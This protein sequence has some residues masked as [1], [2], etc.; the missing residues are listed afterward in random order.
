MKKEELEKFL[1][2]KGIFPSI[3]RIKI[4]EFLQKTKNHP[5]AD[6]IHKIVS[7]Q[8]PTLSRTTVYNTLKL[9][10][11]MK[12]VKSLSIKGNE[13]RYDFQLIPHAHFRCH[14]CGKIYDLEI[15]LNN[16]FSKNEEGHKILEVEVNMN[17][18]CR[19]CLK[20]ENLDK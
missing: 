4:L 15:E 13:T 11:K 7:R 19:N 3:Q 6:M 14:Q 12:I 8:I 10:Q 18:F 17:G 20:K 5:T 1:R 2:E 9:F 16:I